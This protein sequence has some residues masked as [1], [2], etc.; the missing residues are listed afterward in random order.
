MSHENCCGS[1]MPQIPPRRQSFHPPVAFPSVHAL[2]FHLVEGKTL[3][4]IVH[5]NKPLFLPLRNIFLIATQSDT[6]NLEILLRI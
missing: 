5:T 2:H 4:D 6:T 3:A 1:R